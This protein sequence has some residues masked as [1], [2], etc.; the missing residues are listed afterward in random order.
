MDDGLKQRLI[1]AIVIVAVAIIFIPMIFN[2]TQ[3]QGD[4]VRVDIPSRPESPEPQVAKPAKPSVTKEAEAEK[5]EQAPLA[6]QP[7]ENLPMSWVLQVASFQEPKNAEALRDRLRQAGYKAY[8][9]YRPDQGD[10]MARVFVGPEFD[11][12]EIEGVAAKLKKKFK[13]E[14]FVVR[15]LP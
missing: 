6:E 4:D 9:I 1:G 3:R 13:L 10:K 11:R 2:D 7:V 5:S 15:Y 14:G 12:K 8:V